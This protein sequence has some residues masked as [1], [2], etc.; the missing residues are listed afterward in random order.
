[1]NL[2]KFLLE[3]KGNWIQTFSG[4]AFY[5]ETVYEDDIDIIDIAHALGMVCRYSGHAKSFFS[6]AEHSVIVSH[7]VPKG[8]EL[9]G[10]LHDASEAYLTDVPRPIKPMIPYYKELEENLEK[11]IFKKYEIPFPVP[12]EVKEVDNRMLKTE[13][14]QIMFHGPH[15]WQFFGEAFENVKIECWSPEVA[16][17]KFLERFYELVDL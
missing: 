10:L 17:Q 6:V 8:F 1:M 13:Y 2:E 12:P 7:L 16:K 3:R 15:E 9:A 11:V 4:K 14:D 5:P